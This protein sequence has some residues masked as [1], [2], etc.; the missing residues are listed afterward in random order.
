VRKLEDDSAEVRDLR[1]SA[2]DGPG[3]LSEVHVIPRPR[4]ATWCVYIDAVAE[5]LSEHISETAA[6]SAARTQARTRG[7]SRIVIHDR[8]HRT[9]FGAPAAAK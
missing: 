2:R 9:R 7:A 4:A 3:R 6:E 5:A 1:R 8:Y